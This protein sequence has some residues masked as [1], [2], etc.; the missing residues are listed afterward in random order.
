MAATTQKTLIGT[1]DL[2]EA[3]DAVSR[4]YCP[5]EVEIRGSNRGVS[6]T[7]EVIHS[8]VQRVMT[9]EYS[10]PVRIDAGDFRQLMLMMACVDG[11]ATAVQEDARPHGV[12]ISPCR[13]RQVWTASWTSMVA[14]LRGPCVWISSSWRHFRVPELKVER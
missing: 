5:H 7:P 11:S 9:L 13:Y 8:G 10:T 12:A 4:L 3:V 1:S 14:S 6:A 2:T